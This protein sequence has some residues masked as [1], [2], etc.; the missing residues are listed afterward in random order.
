MPA[1]A[2]RAPASSSSSSGSVEATITGTELSCAPW[3]IPSRTA[4]QDSSDCA[5]EPSRLV[6]ENEHAADLRILARHHDEVVEALCVAP[7]QRRVVERVRD[8]GRLG[9]KLPHALARGRR[10][11][12]QR[13][14]DPLALVGGQ[15]RVATGTGEHGQPRARPAR[16]R[17]GERLGELEQLVE[18]RC[19]RAARLLDE[20]AEDALI[21]GQ[22]A[23]VRGGSR[24]RRRAS[25]PPSAPRRRRPPRRSGRAPRTCARRRHP[26]RGRA[27]SSRRPGRPRARRPRPPDRAPPSSRTRRRCADAGRGSRSA[28]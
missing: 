11:C 10:E 25:C 26:P 21:A 6:I 2:K 7:D 12:G 1:S 18:V 8:R 4:A 20:R 28:R 17:H 5:L 24:R 16:A 13:D 14:A 9:Q 3:R 27:R 19:P 23:G 15:R 22:R